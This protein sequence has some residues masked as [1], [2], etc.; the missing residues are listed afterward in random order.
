M[1]SALYNITGLLMDMTQ[2]D[3]IGQLLACK[4]ELES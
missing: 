3:T 2:R 4:G 1:M